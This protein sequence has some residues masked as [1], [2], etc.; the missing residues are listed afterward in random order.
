[1]KIC[2]QCLYSNSWLEIAKIVVPNLVGY[3]RRYD[4]TW[5]I[6]SFH[7]WPSDFGFQ[8][9]VQ[10]QNIFKSN[11]ADVVFAVDADLM[12]TN[13]KKRIEDFL[14]DEHDFFICKDFNGINA[15]V[16]AIRNTEW[17]YGFINYLLSTRGEEGVYCEQDAISLY[18]KD[19]PNNDKI[20][21]VDHPAFNSYLYELY[22]EI[23]P[24]TREQGQWYEWDS[25]LLHLPGIGMEKRLSILQNT[26]VLL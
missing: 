10:I 18:M 21:I 4:Y 13:Y 3:C 5:N 7:N 19:F 14:T 24:Q 11:E 9:L 2:V 16:F 25:F 1:M 8:K 17:S 15:G 22:P 20:K 12:I 26:P 23:P 6:Q